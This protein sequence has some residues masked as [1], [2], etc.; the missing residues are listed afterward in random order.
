MSDK[1]DA[2]AREELKH[3]E[4]E[5]VLAGTAASDYENYLRTDELLSLQKTPA[6][7]THRDEALFQTV[8]QSSELWLKLACFELDEA[9]ALLDADEIRR[10][11]RLLG[12]AN[13]CIVIVS[14][15]LHM[16]E[17]LSPWE[18]H[19]VRKSLG[20]GSGFDSPGFR[21]L[22]ARAPRLYTA[23]EAR[24]AASGLTLAEAYTKAFEH[25]DLYD[26]AEALIEFDERVSIWRDV[27]VKMVQRV[28]GGGAIGTQGTPVAVLA[29]LTSKRL[30]PSLWDVRNT[31]TEIADL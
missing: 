9:V 28:I 3:G 31:L 8:H 6:E 20:H 27:H 2:A 18:Y 17:R 21:E 5:P 11:L 10:A 22:R 24:L 16:L 12:R 25:P 14:A 13:E 26:L 30:Y 15:A 19:E 23:F 1:D 4:L 7:M 29:G